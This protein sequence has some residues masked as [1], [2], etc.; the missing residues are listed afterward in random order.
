MPVP[1]VAALSKAVKITIINWRNTVKK[2]SALLATTLFLSSRQ[3]RLLLRPCLAKV[4]PLKSTGRERGE[5]G[6]RWTKWTEVD[7]VDGG[8]QEQNAGQL[9]CCIAPPLSPLPS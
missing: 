3:K 2:L 6:R 9:L 7:K 5:S 4:A 8:G 1:A